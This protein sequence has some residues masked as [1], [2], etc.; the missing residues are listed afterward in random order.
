MND[1]VKQYLNVLKD[2]CEAAHIKIKLEETW[3]SRNLLE[4][5]R[6]YHYKEAQ[7]SSCSKRITR[8]ASE[9]N[10]V[11]PS[12]NSDIAGI[13]ST[14]ATAA[15]EDSTP[16]YAYFCTI[17]EAALHLWFENEWLAQ[18]PWEYTCCLLLGLQEA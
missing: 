11:I 16:M 3:Y 14:G 5:S 4:Y 15:A 2:L 6:K 18:K 7:V 1:Y 9:A 10:Q 8:L 12:M 17:T 13:F